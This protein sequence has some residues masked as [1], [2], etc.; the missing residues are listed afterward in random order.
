MRLR[1]VG[2][3]VLLERK[4]YCVRNGLYKSLCFGVLITFLCCFKGYHTGHGAEGV[5][6]ATT[7]AVVLSSVAVLVLDYVLNSVLL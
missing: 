2:D 1:A 3:N 5:S 4:F 7:E 6:K